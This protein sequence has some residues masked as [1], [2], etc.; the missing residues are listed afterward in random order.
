MRL[1]GHRSRA[2]VSTWFVR[3]SA[4][5]AAFTLIELLVVIAIIG[6]LIGLLLPAVQSVRESSRRASCQNN[7][8]QIGL[9]CLNHHDEHKVFP[10]GG[11]DFATPPTYINGRPA[12][13]TSQEAGWGFQI[14]PYIEQKSVWEGRGSNDD[15]DRIVQAVGALQ[16]WAFCPSRRSPQRITYSDPYYLGGVEMAHGLC[17]YAGSD[18]EDNGA[19]RRQRPVAIHEVLDGASSTILIGEKRLNLRP[20][21][22]WQEDDNEGYT[23]GWD[24][25]VMRTSK[26]PPQPDYQ[27]DGKG[28]EL[29]GSS[30][31]GGVNFVLADGSVHFIG[32]EI[33]SAVF[34]AYCNKNDR[35]AVPPLE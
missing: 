11:K 29:F 5:C 3:D 21:G 20:L 28:D 23:S 17:D 4:R 13:G 7:L 2:R 22:S 35:I 8:K 9:A 24:E 1:F 27:G 31:A 25:D 18:L 14:L 15:L 26:R 12:T 32:Y 30:H 10:S 34:T 6:I 19:V 16:T 33:E